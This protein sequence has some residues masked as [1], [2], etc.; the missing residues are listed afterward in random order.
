MYITCYMLGLQEHFFLIVYKDW[1]TGNFGEDTAVSPTLLFYRIF[2]KYR[3]T[4]YQPE[5]NSVEK[6]KEEKINLVAIG[7]SIVRNVAK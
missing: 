6:E 2:E 7:T 4:S 5:I 1:R 3:T